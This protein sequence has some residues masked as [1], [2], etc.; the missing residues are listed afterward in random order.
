MNWIKLGG[1]F[2]NFGNPSYNLGRVS[3]ECLPGSAKDVGNS[4]KIKEIS[5]QFYQGN[6]KNEHVVDN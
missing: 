2:L 5:A 3:A 6:E 1:V 4:P